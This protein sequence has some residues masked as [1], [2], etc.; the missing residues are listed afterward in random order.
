MEPSWLTDLRGALRYLAVFF[1]LLVLASVVSGLANGFDASRIQGWQIH[2][3]WVF[4][5]AGTLVYAYYRSR[6]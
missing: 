5:I 4:A 6:R 2:A 1:A 3:S